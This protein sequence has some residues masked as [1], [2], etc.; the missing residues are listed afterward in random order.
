M[1]QQR[2]AQLIMRGADAS[3]RP[4]ADGSKAPLEALLV[5]VER[6]RVLHDEL[7]DA[8]Q[9]ALG[10]TDAFE[11]IGGGLVRKIC[12]VHGRFLALTQ[13]AIVEPLY[14]GHDPRFPEFGTL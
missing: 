10:A 12:V 5:A 9:A 13:Q 4:Q 3:M 11:K 2:F 7:A 1:P 6:V 14:P 8:E